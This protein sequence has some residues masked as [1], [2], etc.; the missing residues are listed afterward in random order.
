MRH[1]Q[2]LQPETITENDFFYFKTNCE[3]IF[4]SNLVLCGVI[5]KYFFLEKIK[6]RIFLFVLTMII[7][8]QEQNEKKKDFGKYSPK[9]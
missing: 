4:F 9:K 8:S 2:F 3:E 6:R 1:L 5:S 7:P